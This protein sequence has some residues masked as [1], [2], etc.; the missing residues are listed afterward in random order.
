M[1]DQ[2]KELIEKINQ[3]GVVA[4]QE[5]AA[6]IEKQAQEEADMIVRKAQ[7]QAKKIVEDA[8]E[9]VER[10][11]ESSRAELQQ[12]GRDFLLGLKEGI[13]GLLE[14]VIVKD[15][16]VAL[17]AEELSQMIS[18]IIKECCGQ[19]GKQAV[20]YLSAPD[21]SKLEGHFLNKLKNE[22][23]NGIELRQGDDIRAG[24]M[25]SFDAG[26]SHFD[27]SEKAL[28]QYLQTQVKP[29]VEQI[30]KDTK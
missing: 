10:L 14:R 13:L 25:I 12:A 8:Q 3:E 1:S 21:K 27:F 22:L 26:K 15:V 23:K 2:I 24:F 30:L 18:G 17:T 16:A 5:K 9:K 20:V 29:K 4:A 19:G 6:Q 28:V 7:A 11:K